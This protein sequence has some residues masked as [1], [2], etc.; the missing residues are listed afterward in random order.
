MCIFEM[1][2]DQL[3]SKAT[4][5]KGIICV[6]SALLCVG[7]IVGTIKFPDKTMILLVISCLAFLSFILSLFDVPGFNSPMYVFLLFLLANIPVVYAIINRL[8]YEG[9]DK[10]YI[11]LLIAFYVLS[12]VILYMMGSMDLADKNSIFVI[13]GIISVC[14]LY[15]MKSLPLS[16]S[17]TFFTLIGMIMLF[18][19]ALHYMINS[20]IWYVYLLVYALVLFYMLKTTPLNILETLKRYLPDPKK[21]ESVFLGAELCAILLYLYTRPVIQKI[22][23]HDG[24]LLVNHPLHLQNQKNLKV[25]KHFNYTYSL[26]FWVYINQNNPS[27]SPQATAFIPFLSYGDKPLFSYNSLRNIIRVEMKTEN[28]LMLVDEITHVKLQKWNHIVVNQDN[29]TIDI[30]VN[31]ELHKS[32][33]GIIPSKDTSELHIGTQH[34]VDG[35][36]CNVMFFKKMLTTEK[37]QN[38]YNNFRDKNPPTF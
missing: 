33:S 34:G 8:S 6:V 14:L 17:K 13:F 37:I 24:K 22:Y 27:S 12:M 32:T 29:G 38:V 20:N 25:N 10:M 5:S 28:K 16:L 26:S 4:N 21:K 35:T 7:A 30:F 31:G 1:F 9:A 2:S 23:V 36:L 11:P 18:M 15:Y 3:D 19:V